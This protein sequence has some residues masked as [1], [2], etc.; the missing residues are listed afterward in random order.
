MLSPAKTKH[1]KMHKGRGSNVATRK[2]DISF[3][4]FALKS[5]E[6]LWVTSRQIEAARKAITH[7]LQKGGKIW[8]RIFPDKPITT[9]G[10]ET[11]MG[12]G[13]GAVDHY[14]AVVKPGMVLF[15][16]DGVEEKVA[17]EALRLASH[18]LPVKT[19][20]IKK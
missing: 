8:I 16:I 2:T 18:K 17:K 4:S 7:Y 19:R 15:E 11:G 6:G 10:S 3:G 20:F 5:M 1:K 14:V 13:K 9:K 12:G